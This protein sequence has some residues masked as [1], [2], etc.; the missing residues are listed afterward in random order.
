MSQKPPAYSG[1]RY[2]VALALT[3]LLFLVPIVAA[4]CWPASAD[5]P[6]PI[7]TATLI[8]P[9]TLE[10]LP[11]PAPTITP[12]ISVPVVRA[13]ATLPPP[14]PTS[15]PPSATAVPTTAPVVATPTAIFKPA[16]YQ[17]PR[18]DQP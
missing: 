4:V 7:P 5:Q 9:P 8:M 14:T 16:P 11:T 2:L 12:Y 1:H 18:R 15:T 3:A 6:V 13:T 10:P 17:V